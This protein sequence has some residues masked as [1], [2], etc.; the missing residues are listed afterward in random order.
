[1]KG[2]RKFDKR[3]L[4]RKLEELERA[5]DAIQAAYWRKVLTVDIAT[6]GYIAKLEARAER[7]EK[8]ASKMIE[9]LKIAAAKRSKT[10]RSNS[11][12][13]HA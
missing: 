8:M 2:I 1:M 3:P 5:S 7:A 10:L 9:R 6:D 12:S 13:S 4:H 11:E